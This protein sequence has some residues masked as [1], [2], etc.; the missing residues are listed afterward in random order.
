MITELMQA[1]AQ[2]APRKA[3]R[4]IATGKGN[5]EKYVREIVAQADAEIDLQNVPQS[6][7]NR[8][9]MVREVA[10]QLALETATEPD[11]ETM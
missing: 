11:P 2:Q 1:M 3:N 9:R 10:M 6:D 5:L 4:I 7:P 8:E